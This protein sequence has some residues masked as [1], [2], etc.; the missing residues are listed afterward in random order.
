MASA[1]SRRGQVGCYRGC[2]AAHRAGYEIERAADWSCAQVVCADRG[3]TPQAKQVHSAV[4]AA[5]AWP[6][7]HNLISHTRNIR[8][9][10]EGYLRRRRRSRN[11]SA[12]PR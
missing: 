6:L 12:R 7:I 8:G 10:E 4:S 3:I 11:L 2:Q 1:E 5:C 9:N